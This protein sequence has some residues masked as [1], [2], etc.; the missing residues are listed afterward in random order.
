MGPFV[1]R[2]SKMH[3]TGGNLPHITV[4]IVSMCSRVSVRCRKQG[5]THFSQMKVSVAMQ[6]LDAHVPGPRLFQCS[7]TLKLYR[8]RKTLLEGTRP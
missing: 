7:R 5:R 4:E 6:D 3:A 2:K 8:S 1:S